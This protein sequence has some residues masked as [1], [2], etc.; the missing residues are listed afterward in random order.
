[1]TERLSDSDAIRLAASLPPE[2]PHILGV[3]ESDDASGSTEAAVVIDI[4]E[5]EDALR[6]PKW[7]AFLSEAVAYR[8]KLR[9]EGRIV[10]H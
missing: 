10:G 8:Q 9:D 7:Q 4:D 2:A 1:M 6:D 5:F 3:A